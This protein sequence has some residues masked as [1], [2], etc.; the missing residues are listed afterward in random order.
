ML[1]PYIINNF[2]II[3]VDLNLLYEL[4]LTEM[5]HKLLKYTNTYMHQDFFSLSSTEYC[6]KLFIDSVINKFHTS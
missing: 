5:Y 6:I 3:I 2:F 4:N 1:Q